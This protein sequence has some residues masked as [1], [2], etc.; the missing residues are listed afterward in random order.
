M[1]KK[2]KD[3]KLS[4]KIKYLIKDWRDLLE[5]KTYNFN[6]SELKNSRATKNEIKEERSVNREKRNIKEE[7]KYTKYHSHHDKYG[8]FKYIIL[9]IFFNFKKQNC[10]IYV[11]LFYLLI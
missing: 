10:L 3:E 8:N 4:K 2:I 1:R 11:S 7:D 6:V 9:N 5:N